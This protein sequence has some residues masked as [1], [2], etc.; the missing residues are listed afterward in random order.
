VPERARV[1]V[2]DD[3]PDLLELVAY[4]LERAGHEVELARDGAE[5]LDAVARN[6]PDLILLDLMMPNIS[7]LEVARRLKAQG[8]AP[9][10]I[11]LTAKTDEQDELGGLAQG[12]DDY[13]TKPFSI[14]VLLAR[15]EAVL[16]RSAVPSSETSVS[17]GPLRINQDNHEI[18]LRD[19]PL[20]V[21]ITEFRLLSSLAEAKGRV[22]SRQA[23][24][25]SAMGPGVTVTE[26][27]IDVH[28]TSIRKKL[29]LDS[30]LIRTVRG[31]GYRLT[32]PSDE[33][34]DEPETSVRAGNDAAGKP[35]I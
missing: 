14:K 6:R 26:R 12:A 7:G 20:I 22:L 19:E 1:L 34:G 15:I 2:V 23:L 8:D 27:T 31:V 33:P 28:I 4:N 24:I 16:R 10:I 9:P 3:E 29:G 17:V 5:A 30:G 25:S 13:V 35:A 21:T 18:F 32:A 11:M